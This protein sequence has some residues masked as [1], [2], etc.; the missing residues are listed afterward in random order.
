[1]EGL[2]L[3]IEQDKGKVGKNFRKGKSKDKSKGEGKAMN[4]IE[5]DDE[6][7]TQIKPEVS[8][9]EAHEWTSQL[10]RTTGLA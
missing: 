9:L 5:G 10:T 4:E 2:H 7:H 8:M 1:M 6:E 3:A